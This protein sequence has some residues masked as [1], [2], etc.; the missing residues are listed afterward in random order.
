MVPLILL[1]HFSVVVDCS[2]NDEALS[3]GFSIFV[4]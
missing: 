3:V 1:Q 2:D 4:F